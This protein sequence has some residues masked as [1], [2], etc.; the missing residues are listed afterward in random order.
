MFPNKK[1]YL[2]KGAK[3]DFVVGKIEG[4]GP[5]DLL[6]RLTLSMQKVD[7]T[8][9]HIGFVDASDE[10]L[11]Y[12]KRNDDNKKKSDEDVLK[13]LSFLLAMINVEKGF[14]E[15][16]HRIFK[17][18]NSPDTYELTIQQLKNE[19]WWSK[20][21]LIQDSKKR[22]YIIFNGQRYWIP[23]P[24]T[25]NILGYRA[26]K[27]VPQNESEINE[28]PPADHNLESILDVPLIRNEN[29]PA[30][31]YAKFNFPVVELRHIPD[32]PTLFAAKR[33]H[34]QVEPISEEEFKK[35]PIGSQLTAVHFWDELPKSKQNEIK[36]F[37][38]IGQ[39][40]TNGAHHN[41]QNVKQPSQGQH[42]KWTDLWWVRYVIFPVVVGL[43]LLLIK[44]L[45]NQS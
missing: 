7:T 32:E 9:N 45:L 26:S 15:D 11:R 40:N 29:N 42:K 20:V 17:S 6:M 44:G 4:V 33:T 18:K 2:S 31:V 39:L 14:K 25:R 8:D 22:K 12:Q 23:D 34:Q 27:F 36:Q 19:L 43:I 24:I 1:T 28:Y 16:F 13:E 38:T 41:T 3:F 35:Y 5:L 30:P 10:F 37:F 21:N